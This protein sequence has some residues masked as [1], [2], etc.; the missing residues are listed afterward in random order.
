MTFV[1]LDC[2]QP[3]GHHLDYLVIGNVKHRSQSPGDYS[4]VLSN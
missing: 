1:G 2:F 4:V 3:G